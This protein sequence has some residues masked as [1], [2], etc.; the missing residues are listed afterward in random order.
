M[1]FP[2]DCYDPETLDLMTR[3]LDVACRCDA[4]TR[5]HSRCNCNIAV[6]TQPLL[7]KVPSRSSRAACRSSACVFI[8]I[9]PYQAMGSRS[10]RPETSNN[11]NSLFASLGRGLIATAERRR[12]IIHSSS[13]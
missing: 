4:T 2:S 7:M 10:G 13:P 8:T 6:M 1:P 9:G 3:A 11:R 12:V 5:R